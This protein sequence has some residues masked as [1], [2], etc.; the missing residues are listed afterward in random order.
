[1]DMDDLLGNELLLMETHTPVS[2]CFHVNLCHF[3]VVYCATAA[4][5]VNS[6]RGRGL[7]AVCGGRRTTIAS[8][9]NGLWRLLPP[10]FEVF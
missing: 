9:K 2:L 4:S 5:G 6:L 10:S 1:M 3:A 8:T 7:A